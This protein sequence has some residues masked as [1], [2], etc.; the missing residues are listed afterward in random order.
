[1]ARCGAAK[2]AT[3]STPEEAAVA[4]FGAAEAATLSNPDLWAEPSSGTGW[5]ARGSTCWLSLLQWQ[6]QN[7]VNTQLRLAQPA[8]LRLGPCVLRQVL[9]EGYSLDY[10]E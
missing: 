5:V 3:L 6:H 1:M 4:R 9:R 7:A 2:A 8:W 10:I